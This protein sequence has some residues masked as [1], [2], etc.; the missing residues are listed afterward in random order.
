MLPILNVC[1]LVGSLD[2]GDLRGVPQLPL[3][4]SG[5]GQPLDTV[6]SSPRSIKDDQSHVGSLDCLITI[7]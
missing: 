5:N 2:G 1:S 6:S 3:H 7:A 4:E